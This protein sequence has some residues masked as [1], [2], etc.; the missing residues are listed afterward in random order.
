M[1]S[2]L[3]D[4]SRRDIVSILAPGSQACP[5]VCPGQSPVR[6]AP[7]WPHC[8]PI[9]T[10]LQQPG[11]WVPLPNLNDKPWILFPSSGP[12][13]LACSLLQ[14]R[15]PL[16]QWPLLPSSHPQASVSQGSLISLS[17]PDFPPNYFSALAHKFPFVSSPLTSFSTSEA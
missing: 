8:G 4:L 12:F 7:S 3:Q 2:L 1:L 5:G 14:C 16:S 9:S 15:W 11:I 13:C 10:L 17:H 6:F